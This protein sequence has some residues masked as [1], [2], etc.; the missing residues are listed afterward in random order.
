MICFFS[1]FPFIFSS[2]FFLF[3]RL[4]SECGP[5]VD[6]KL[7]TTCHG[8]VHLSFSC[9]HTKTHTL[10]QTQTLS[11]LLTHIHTSSH[12]SPIFYLMNATNMTRTNDFLCNIYCTHINLT[13]TKLNSVSLSFTHT[14]T[15]TH[16]H[17]SQL[18][19]EF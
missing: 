12:I 18:F 11:D 4:E 3:T 1:R 2:P 9:A 13:C 17:Y 8:P 7:S 16:T 19:S 6:M 10:A 14:H 15:H 5:T